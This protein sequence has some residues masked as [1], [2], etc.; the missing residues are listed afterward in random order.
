V[1]AK[2]PQIKNVSEDILKEVSGWKEYNQLAQKSK[3][4]N[5]AKRV[6]HDEFIVVQMKRVV[7]GHCR[8]CP[9]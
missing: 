1:R 2:I 9:I 6:L 3:E 4:L 7:P 8:Y 5:Q